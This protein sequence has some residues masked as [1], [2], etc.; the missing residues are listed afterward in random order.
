M[1]LHV[2]DTGSGGR[3]FLDFKPLLFGYSTGHLDLWHRDLGG[4]PSYQEGAGAL[5]SQ[6][7]AAYLGKESA[8]T[9]QQD[10]GLPPDGGVHVGIGTGGYGDIY[11][12]ASEY[13]HTIYSNSAY[14]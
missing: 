1:G 4:D 11:I 3:G 14:S 2:K 9:S 13:G 12:H 6:V 8:A 5:P 10:M 7:G